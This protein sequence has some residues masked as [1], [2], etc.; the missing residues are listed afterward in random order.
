MHYKV[1]IVLAYFASEKLPEPRVEFRFHPQRLWRFDFCF[2]DKLVALEVEGG[3]WGGGRHTRGAG[4]AKDIEKYNAA[5]LLGWR[6][7]RVQPAQLCML[8][9]VKMLKQALGAT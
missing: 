4:F 2:P 8:D 1:Q 7:F 6:I 5:A 9:T 3:I